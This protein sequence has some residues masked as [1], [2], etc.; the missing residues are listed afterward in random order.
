MVDGWATREQSTSRARRHQGVEAVVF[1]RRLIDHR[2]TDTR[3]RRWLVG[4]CDRLTDARGPL[5]RTE[6]AGGAGPRVWPRAAVMP[7]GY[8]SL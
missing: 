6:R 8:F 2:Q 5:S 1:A 3:H 4:A 7:A